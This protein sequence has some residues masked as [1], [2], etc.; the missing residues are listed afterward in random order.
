MQK[1]P[2]YL[3]ILTLLTVGFYFYNEQPEPEFVETKPAIPRMAA[4]TEIDF[5]IGD[6]IV[7]T[8]EQ[9]YGDLL[10]ESTEDMDSVDY[11]S[12]S[13]KEILRF[14][15]S[16]DKLTEVE[17][18]KK[19]SHEE[20]I[21]N[22]I[23]QQ[24]LWE[25]FSKVIPAENRKMVKEFT[26]ITDGKDGTLGY[27]QQHFNS[28]DWTLALDYNDATNLN[29]LYSTIV[30]EYGHLFSLNTSE[31]TIDKACATL[32]YGDGC[33]KENAYVYHFY[34][35]FWQDSM[36]KEWKKIEDLQYDYPEQTNFFLAHSDE[37]VS[38][39]ATSH[40]IED[41]AESWMYFILSEK[42]ES[43]NIADDKV[44][45]FYE[46]PELV[47]LRNDILINLQKNYQ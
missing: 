47:Q 17:R 43:Y 46:Y 29:G 7:H 41:F 44:L 39:Y 19:D 3:L 14:T 25:R 1:L 40:L 6:K 10:Y 13:E 24:Q 45:F 21:N 28:A 11:E 15:V 12:E 37:F 18:S 31:F 35:D 33:L 42:P 4:T 9:K 5:S 22:D 36:M 2:L 30:H 32:D 20:F 26:I 38:E 23:A 27:V 8:L 16:N 34:Q